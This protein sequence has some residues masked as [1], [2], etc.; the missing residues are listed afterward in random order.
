[1][2]DTL[3]LPHVRFSTTDY[4]RLIATGLLPERT[5]LI[6]GELL[7]MAAVGVYTQATA[8]LTDDYAPD[9]D[10]YVTRLPLRSRD[11]LPAPDI[12]LA[13]EV[14]DTTWARDYNIKRPRYAA[15]GIP[16]YWIV[17]LRDRQLVVCTAPRD[18]EYQSEQ[19]LRE[20]EFV[21]PTTFAARQLQVRALLPPA[22]LPIL[23]SDETA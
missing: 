11:G 13:I 5:E 2:A 3:P 12:L 4:G 14:C 8:S 10:L 1:M 22:D 6:D 19:T 7:S 23:G 21:Q 18:G 15:A 20:D 16:E 17:N 9:P